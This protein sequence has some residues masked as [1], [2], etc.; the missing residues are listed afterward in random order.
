VVPARR[1]AEDREEGEPENDDTSA[2][3]L[4][5]ADVLLSE[6]VAERER[7]DHRRH[8]Q[9]LDDGQPPV[10]ESDRL[11][12]VSNE[13]RERSDEPPP[14]LDETGERAQ[15]VGRDRKIQR[16]LLLQRRRDGEEACRDEG[17]ELGH[18]RTLTRRG[19]TQHLV[20]V[21]AVAD[22]KRAR[23]GGESRLPSKRA[24]KGR[25][26][27]SRPGDD[28]KGGRMTTLEPTSE[29]WTSG[30]LTF[31]AIMMYAV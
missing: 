10:I 25:E 22:G 27:G 31:A 17:E 20:A 26:T 12:G 29:K 9:R 7:E 16:A 1:L 14:A 5:P 19:R 2:D 8:E 30:W 23:K 24:G 15:A 13:E 6:H 21:C 28:R 18:V 4:S 11:H 3:D